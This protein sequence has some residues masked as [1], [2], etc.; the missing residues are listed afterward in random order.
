MIINKTLY[1]LQDITV[2]PAV[3]STI[4]HRG[5][6]NVYYEMD[7]KKML[8]IFTSPMDTVVSTK[9]FTQFIDNKITPILPRTESLDTRLKYLNDSMWAAVSLHEFQIYFC[10]GVWNTKENTSPVY[11]ADFYTV[12][13]NHDK[14]KPINVL[15]DMANGHISDLWV[16]IQNAKKTAKELGVNLVVMAGNIANPQ[17][18]EQ[19]ADAGADYIRINV[20]GGSRC[21]TSANTS[22][23]YAMASLIDE[24]HTYKI[25]NPKYANVKIIAD[26]GIGSYSLAIK[27]LACG[28]D[29]VMIGNLF[30][31]TFE[32]AS[33]FKGMHIPEKVYEYPTLHEL[34]DGRTTYAE[35][36]KKDI[37]KKYSPLI[38]AYYG[39]STR[40]AQEK[41]LLANGVK[42]SDIKTKTAE[43]IEKDVTV[44]YTLYQWTDNFISYLRSAMSYCSFKEIDKFVGG[45]Q[46]MLLSD[47]AKNAINK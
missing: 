45:P 41:I 16:S 35:Q 4:H 20:G 36:E 12:F 7:G 9:N 34:N 43:G 39:M 33:E 42:K 30:A 15:I 25:N 18:F 10:K 22:V 26:G 38:K 37:I 28:A 27:A 17:A 6:C 47:G 29:F 14:N 11:S 1:A 32:S 46:I 2:V 3:V 21:T 24:C 44:D 19:L 31:K 5:E 40:K 13:S 8:P 23:H